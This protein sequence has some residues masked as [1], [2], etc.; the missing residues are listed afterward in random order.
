M[1][2]RLSILALALF[3]PSLCAAQVSGEGEADSGSAETSEASTHEDLEAFRAAY[4]RYEDRV[5]EMH[6]EIKRVVTLRYEEELDRIR[7]SYDTQTAEKEAEERIQRLEAIAQHEEF[8]RKYPDSPYTAHRIFRLANLYLDETEYAFAEA[9]AAYRDLEEE[10]DRKLEAGEPVDALPEPPGRDYSRAIALMQD[11][12]ERFPDY[13]HLGATYYLLGYCYWDELSA[14]Q[15]DGLAMATYRDLVRRLPDSNYAVNGHFALGEIYFNELEFEAAIHHY[16]K[17]LDF[18]ETSH[19]DRALYKLAWA[20]YRGDDLGNAIPKFVQLIDYS[21]QMLTEGGKESDMRPEA[22]RYLAISLVDQ[23]DDVERPPI[24]RVEEYFSNTGDRPYQYDVMV[25]VDDVLSQQARYDEELATLIRIQELYPNSPDNPEFQRRIMAL[26]VNKDN[27]DV[28]ASVAARIELV[29]RFKEGTPWWEANKNNPDALRLASQ[30]IEES[31]GDVAKVYHANAQAMFAASGGVR[32][33]EPARSE[34]MRAAEAYQDYLDRFPFTSDAYTTQFYIAECYYWAGEFEQAIA[35]YDKLRRYPDKTYEGETFVAVAFSYEELMRQREGNYK[36]NPLALDNFEIDLGAKPETIPDIPISDLRQKYIAAT[37]ALNAYDPNY[38]DMAR[39]Q[40]IVA[41]IFYFH[42]KIDEARKRFEMIIDRYPDQDVA[43]FS[44]GLLVNSYHKTGDVQMVFQMCDRF[45][46]VPLLG[47]DEEYWQTKLETYETKRRNAQFRLAEFAAGTDM[48]EGG[49]LFEEYYREHADTENEALALFNA[50]IWNEKAGD[51][52]KANE[53]YEEFLDEFGEHDDAPSI[54]FRIAEQYERTMDLDRAIDYYVR[55]A[56]LHPE[57]E[58]APDAYYNAAFLSIGLGNFEDAASYYLTYVEDFEVEDAPDAYWRAAEAYRDGGLDTKALDAYLEYNRRF[59]DEKID[60]T[61]QSLVH[62]L[63]IYEAQGKTRMVTKTEEELLEYYHALREAGRIGEL[64][65]DSVAVVAERAFPTLLARIDEY[66]EIRLPNTQDQEKLKPV[67]DEKKAM[68][69]DISAEA[70]EFL[71]TYPDFD[72]IMACLFIMADLYRKFA[73]M[74]YAWDPPIPAAWRGDEDAELDFIDLID[75]IKI[76]LAEPQE[77]KA[78]ELFEVVLARARELKQNSP[79]VERAR[80]ALHEADPNTY[81]LLK[82][83]R[84]QY[85]D[86]PYE[87]PADPMA[88]PVE[89]A[90]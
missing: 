86:S 38:D 15:D 23:A 35:E 70:T 60:R 66:D 24:G 16:S 43:A 89:E 10:F 34:Y 32:G 68:A 69:Q 37:D 17:V 29:E 79:W 44:A 77:M 58:S 7:S 90:S 8:I 85:S 6:D 52:V 61:M 80:E 47:S 4:S 20:Y 88:R 19:Y 74:I 55:V 50:A 14:Q 18:G 84:I 11:I 81:P 76:D 82:P 67:L 49:R 42:N 33:Q 65:K 1:I 25:Q 59:P 9:N 39:M 72:H 12:I 13:H 48:K 27:P 63:K 5:R 54:F 73:D 46:R 26:H 45:L 64:S 3:V 71:N 53:L 28:D 75:E 78:I 51:T 2:Y 41:E 62:R 56:R 83:D 31:L 22:V 21:D 36:D 30:Y 57:Y 40:Y 87:P